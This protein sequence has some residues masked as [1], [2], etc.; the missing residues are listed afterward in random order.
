ML[1]DRDCP[2]YLV[3]WTQLEDL[4]FNQKAEEISEGKTGA[5]DGKL[6]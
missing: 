6:Y 3:D 2:L 4:L 1:D 5:R